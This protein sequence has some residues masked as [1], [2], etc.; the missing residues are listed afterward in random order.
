MNYIMGGECKHN[1]RMDINPICCKKDGF[2][3]NLITQNYSPPIGWEG[4]GG[5]FRKE[6]D[7]SMF[8][9]MTL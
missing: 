3:A 1:E 9:P 6:I 2:P 5:I 8:E 4:Q 7:A